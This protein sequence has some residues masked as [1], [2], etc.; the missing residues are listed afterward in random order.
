MG[1]AWANR[2]ARTVA[3]I[4]F[5][6]LTACD[7]RS[8]HRPVAPATLSDDEIVAVLNQRVGDGACCRLESGAKPVRE[9]HF[10]VRRRLG[11]EEIACGYSGFHPPPRTGDAPPPLDE[12]TFIV[13]GRRM[14]LESDV[15][16][17]SFGQLQ[18]QLCGPDWI[19]G[20]PVVARPA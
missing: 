2:R 3:L 16:A 18:D 20:M 12:T 13:R 11:A 4:A 15:G 6:T 8:A 5:L 17:Q 7:A 14:I 9:L 19:E 10:L 1:G